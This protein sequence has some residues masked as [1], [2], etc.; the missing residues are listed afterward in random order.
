[1]F[2]F[3]DE[4]LKRF[5]NYLHTEKLTLRDADKLWRTRRERERERAIKKLTVTNSHN[6]ERKIHLK[7]ISN[8]GRKNALKITT[9]IRHRWQR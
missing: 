5:P 9:T 4:L 7:Q 3:I 8:E 6:A 1:M 2:S